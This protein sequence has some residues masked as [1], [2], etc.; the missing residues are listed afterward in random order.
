[1]EKRMKRFS[2][3]GR[4]IQCGPGPGCVHNFRTVMIFC[5]A[6]HWGI[7]S[8]TLLSLNSNVYKKHVLFTTCRGY[9]FQERFPFNAVAGQPQNVFVPC[10]IKICKIVQVRWTRYGVGYCRG[11]TALLHAYNC[12]DICFCQRI[13]TIKIN[14]QKKKT[15]RINSFFDQLV[16]HKCHTILYYC[17]YYLNL[18]GTSS[19]ILCTHVL[20]SQLT[21]NTVALLWHIYGVGLQSVVNI[22]NKNFDNIFFS[23]EKTATL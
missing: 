4:Y 11:A 23:I 1:M 18:V 12:T 14:K 13:N 20:T 7:D 6:P 5:F 10:P 21:H 19:R 2:T 8:I 3:S 17:Y 22:K 16:S 15:G 9:Y